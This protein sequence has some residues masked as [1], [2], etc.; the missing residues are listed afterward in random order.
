MGG[1]QI[2]SNGV[3][4]LVRIASMQIIWKYVIPYGNTKT[5]MVTKLPIRIQSFADK[6]LFRTNNVD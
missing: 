4:N 1:E 2:G 6:I 3:R 5:G